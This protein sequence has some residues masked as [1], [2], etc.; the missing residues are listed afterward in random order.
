MDTSQHLT[1]SILLRD[2]CNIS[3]IINWRYIATEPYQI[4][5]FRPPAQ[6]SFIVCL[7]IPTATNTIRNSFTI[8]QLRGH[9]RKLIHSMTA[10]NTIEYHR[11]ICI[12]SECNHV[13]LLLQHN[14]AVTTL[15]S[16]YNT[17]NIDN[18][19][20]RINYQFALNQSRLFFVIVL[21]LILLIYK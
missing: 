14:T 15:P 8:H 21:I 19:I 13:S 9:S 3:G 6:Q 10:G 17:N 16:D 2:E 5:Q 18:N 1:T 4:I 11:P 7:T 20:T 12:Q